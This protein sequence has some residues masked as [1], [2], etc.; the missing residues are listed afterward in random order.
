MQMCPARDLPCDADKMVIVNLQPTIMDD[1]AWM[2]VRS[3]IDDVL[4]GVMRALEIPIPV[5]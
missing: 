1:E 4:Y 3:K 2:V 5:R